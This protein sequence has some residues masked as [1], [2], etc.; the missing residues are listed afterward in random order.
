MDLETPIDVTLLGPDGSEGRSFQAEAVDL[1][2]GG[3]LLRSEEPVEP[4]TAVRLAIH[5][6][7]GDMAAIARVTRILPGEGEGRRI[8]V[9]FLW[10]GPAKS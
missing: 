8:G 2:E 6:P 4:G 7:S 3:V 10:Y 9:Y 1:S 5:L